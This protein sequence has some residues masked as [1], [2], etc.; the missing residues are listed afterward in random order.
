MPPTSR[1]AS[2]VLSDAEMDALPDAPPR[3]SVVLSD[4]EFDALPDAMPSQGM[5]G[6]LYSVGADGRLV[7][8]EG[9]SR[10]QS[11]PANFLAGAANSIAKL[12]PLAVRAAGELGGRLPRIQPGFGMVPNRDGSIPT[13]PVAEMFGTPQERADINAGANAAIDAAV[14]YDPA[15]FSGQAGAFTVNSVPPLAATVVGGPVAGA[16]VMGAMGVGTAAQQADAAGMTGTP[17]A[18]VYILGRGGLD[19][20]FGFVGGKTGEFVA[21]RFGS[22]AILAAFPQLNQAMRAGDA[23]AAQRIIG[24]I[25]QGV[26]AGDRAVIGKLTAAAGAKTMAAAGVGAGE[27]VLYAGADN[28]LARQTIEPERLMTQGMGEMATLGA[29]FPLAGGLYAVGRAARNVAASRAPAPTPTESPG[30]RPVSARVVDPATGQVVDVPAIPA[31][32]PEAPPAPPAADINVRPPFLDESA[33]AGGNTQGPLPAGVAAMDPSRAEMFQSIEAA[34]RET[35]YPEG[36]A[37]VDLRGRL[38][39]IRAEQMVAEDRQSAAML[40]EARV[41]RSAAL[42]ITGE[43]STPP[44]DAGTTDAGLVPNFIAGRQRQQR[45]DELALMVAEGDLSATRARQIAENRGFDS[46]FRQAWKDIRDLTGPRP[47]AQP[48]FMTRRPTARGEVGGPLPVGVAAPVESPAPNLNVDSMLSGEGSVT[49]TTTPAPTEAPRPASGT[50][51]VGG[52]GDGVSSG[53]LQESQNGQAGRIPA[54]EAVQQRNDTARGVARAPDRAPIRRVQGTRTGITLSGGRE[55]PAAYAAVEA[56]DLIP[57]HDARRA[58]A[59]NEGGDPNERPYHDPQEGKASRETVFKIANNPDPR[60]ILSDNPTP[61]DGPPMVGPDGRVV[62]GNARSMGVQLAYSR[63]GKPAERIRLAT[64]EAAAKFGIDRAAIEGMKNPVIVRVMDDA[65]APGELSRDLNTSL[66]TGKTSATNAA[67][68]ANKLT[69][70][71][72]ARFSDMLGDDESV[73][74]VLGDPERGSELVRMFLRDGA[75]TEQD[76]PGFVNEGTGLLNDA[77]KTVIEETMLGKVVP[78][79]SVLGRMPGSVR[80][81]LLAAMPEMLAVKGL[82]EKYDLMPIVFRAVD[83]IPEYRASGETLDDFFFGQMTMAPRPGAGDGATAVMVNAL[84]TMGP[85]VFRTAVRT[86][87]EMVDAGATMFSREPTSQAKALAESFG[88]NV[89]SPKAIA[90]LADAPPSPQAESPA[91]PAFYEAETTGFQPGIFG[92]PEQLEKIPGRTPSMFGETKPETAPA[93]SVKA[94]A[95]ALDPKN[96]AEM[97]KPN[98]ADPGTV[99]DSAGSPVPPGPNAKPE[100]WEAWAKSQMENPVDRTPEASDDGGNGSGLR[101]SIAPRQEGLSGP[102]GRQAGDGGA[103]SVGRR[104]QAGSQGP[105]AVLGDVQEALARGLRPGIVSRVGRDEWHVQLT[106]VADR[107]PLRVVAADH[108][109]LRASDDERAASLVEKRHG[110]PEFTKF[111]MLHIPDTVADFKAMPPEHQRAILD[112]Y[113]VTGAYD[114]R[115]KSIAIANDLTPAQVANAVHEELFHAKMR[116]LPRANVDALLRKYRNDD[117]AYEEFKGANLTGP[118]FDLAELSFRRIAEDVPQLMPGVDP[119]GRLGRASRDGGGD[120]GGDLIPSVTRKR[121]APPDDRTVSLQAVIGAAKIAKG[122]DKLVTWTKA[123]E[124]AGVTFA[125]AE[126][127]AAVWKLARRYAKM[128]PEERAAAFLKLAKTPATTGSTKATVREATGQVDR[129]RLVRESKALQASL[130]AAVKASD[131]GWRGAVRE[132]SGLRN[133]FARLV[134]ENLPAGEREGMLARLKSMNTFADLNAGVVALRRA[135]AAYDLRDAISDYKAVAASFDPEKLKPSFRDKAK[136]IVDGISARKGGDAARAKAEAM[137]DYVD[138]N[139]DNLVPDDMIEAAKKLLAARDIGAMDPADIRAATEALRAIKHQAELWNELRVRGQVREA[140]RTV[141]AV[142]G[143]FQGVP[144]MKVAGPVDSAGVPLGDPA[145]GFVSKL[146]D[147][148]KNP[149]ATAFEL[150]KGQ[151]DGP[152]QDLLGSLR[153]GKSE[154]FT[155]LRKSIERVGEVLDANALGGWGSRALL[156]FAQEVVETPGIK[157]SPIAMTRAQRIG[158]AGNLMDPDTRAKIV[159]NGFKVEQRLTGE[160]YRVNDEWADRFLAELDPRERAVI[161]AL[162]REYNGEI[163]DQQNA[164]FVRMLGFEKLKNPDY[165]P[166]KADRTEAQ[167]APTPGTG[168]YLR[169]YLESMG[170]FKDRESHG[171]PMVVEDA[172]D[173][174]RLNYF[175]AAN[176]VANAENLHAMNTVLG[177][178][179]VANAVRR[180]YGPHRLT[181]LKDYAL[182]A[183]L[184][185]APGELDVGV[186]LLERLQGNATRAALAT[187]TAAMVQATGILN[188]GIDLGPGNVARALLTITTRPRSIAEAWASLRENDGIMWARY[189]GD[190]TNLISPRFDREKE[191]YGRMGPIASIK[192]DPSILINPVKLAK[193]INNHAL[194]PMQA[195]DQLNAIVAYLALPDSMPPAERAYRAGQAVTRTQNAN[196]PIDY[197]PTQIASRTSF[198]SKATN[199]FGSQTVAVFSLLNR[200]RVRWSHSKKTAKDHARFAAA[201]ATAAVGASVVSQLM[202]EGWKF[203]TQGER[204]EDEKRPYEMPIRVAEDAASVLV[205]PVV[206]NTASSL[207]QTMIGLVRGQGGVNPAVYVRSV[208]DVARGVNDLRKAFELAAEEDPKAGE[209]FAKASNRLLYGV[210]LLTGQSWLNLGTQVSKAATAR[211]FKP[212]PEDPR[213]TEKREAGKA[214]AEVRK[215][216]PGNVRR[217]LSE[218]N[219][220][221]YIGVAKLT[222]DERQ[223]R[224]ELR[225]LDRAA[226]RYLHFTAKG[227]PSP[228]GHWK[229]VMEQEAE[230]LGE[231]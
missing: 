147:G 146:L 187:P 206:A 100:E 168:P 109:S 223:R 184:N 98:A 93:P 6:A 129:T 213:I 137:L 174:Y 150:D 153:R 226:E 74:D 41:A 92:Q 53:Q 175:R 156:D 143:T 145:P 35:P 101:A 5:T 89:K 83:A 195:M 49:A 27:G 191:A 61:A 86:Y 158:L 211:T 215:E 222:E 64:A 230:R 188:L 183:A 48:P 58:F 103:A 45:A 44:S 72:I 112:E 43:G 15:R 25:V 20:A 209:K 28:T 196:D 106:G 163:K 55:E 99:I 16:A 186:Q 39:K 76:V 219:R 115:N 22:Q 94:S 104:A 40:A 33:V 203:V 4:E 88:R 8:S 192:D 10:G 177:T 217:L 169:R 124:A 199:A 84:E 19:A 133:E 160:A 228:A 29:A 68:R 73:R 231:R 30:V 131:E 185:D 66:T 178:P 189:A 105:D 114:L 12:G 134:R 164:V 139:P 65:G 102:Q 171:L 180:K 23:G 50:P 26:Q 216:L 179:G 47:D 224:A 52:A 155:S 202:R 32:T 166:S 181:A 62:G 120:A 225:L 18:N 90:S 59:Q 201:V 229:S 170:M 221:D 157:G 9:P 2:I 14:P 75:W 140:A 111:G 34:A 204:P 207:A 56:D 227:M 11:E 197:A 176:F 218:K 220:L 57:S 138:R 210:S 108:P 135:H 208:E 142:M 182:T 38:A 1:P 24:G 70:G 51:D 122:T 151:D 148:R 152:W 116:S 3:S 121:S 172:F 161:D 17:E 128:D 149:D 71:T 159:A 113:R 77:G 144:D 200:E 97:F 214:A 69:G 96:T 141:E 126:H 154:A 107:V 212:E 123:V 205:G 60:L 78:D 13:A 37:P 167:T 87:R 136:A 194:D 7:P 81:R 190:P 85:R 173:R 63:G 119:S 193:W 127:R 82:G 95:S 118:A 54:P 31:P 198:A 130:R 165:Y 80:Q 110:K 162:R 125:N 67:S 36:V 132:S 21:R 91:K 117:G 42:N 79:P 46:E